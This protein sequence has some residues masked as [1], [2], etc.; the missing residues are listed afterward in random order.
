MGT[1]I[2]QV[3]PQAAVFV[4][5]NFKQSSQMELC[6]NSMAKI[7]IKQLHTTRMKSQLHR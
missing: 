6:Q 7:I 4:E 3:L 5:S 1:L 2:D